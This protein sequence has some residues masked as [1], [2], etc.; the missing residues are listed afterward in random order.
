MRT[1]NSHKTFDQ[2]NSH[3][4]Y[5]QE[6]LEQLQA[7]Y[8]LDDLRAMIKDKTWGDMVQASIK[9]YATEGV[10]F[11]ARI[12][13][14]MNR[15]SIAVCALNKIVAHR[16]ISPVVVQAPFLSQHVLTGNNHSGL[17]LLPTDF[18]NGRL[19]EIKLTDL[20]IT[21]ENSNDGAY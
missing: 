20:V 8:T 14:F 11:T 10:H 16:F 15:P 7:Q 13:K 21:D 5:D 18:Q 19:A 9:T 3:K 17:V 6:R 4:F 2:A 1:A 12:G